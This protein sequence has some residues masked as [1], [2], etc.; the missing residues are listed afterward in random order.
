MPELPEVEN[1]ARD[2]KPLLVGRRIQAVHVY[3]PR[4]VAN[5]TPEAFAQGLVGRQ[6]VNADR[7][8]KYLLF[9]LDNHQT[10]ILHLRMTGQVKLLGAAAEPDVHTHVVMELDNGRRLHYR[11]PRKFGRFYLVSDPAQVVGKLGPEPLRESFTPIDLFNA[12]Q[13]RRVAIKVLLLDQTVVAGIGN[14]YA[15]E[16]LFLAGIDPRRPGNSLTLADCNRLH[17]CIRQLLAEAIR[18]GGS[19]LG[20]SGLSNYERPVGVM[21]QYQHRHRVFRRASKPCPRCG[22]PIERIKLA[23]RSTHFCPRCQDNGLIN[24]AEV[25]A[26]P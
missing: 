13:G 20:R 18:E 15:D 21:G 14:I 16:A 19:S 22:T 12:V 9:P 7:R 6:I 5:L 23:Q 1:Y 24:T 4:T 25:E 26:R 10:L 8:G 11:D 2:L 3:W 17:T